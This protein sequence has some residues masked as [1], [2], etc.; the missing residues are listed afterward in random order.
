LA[1]VLVILLPFGYSL[2]HYAFAQRDETQQV[3]LERPDAQYEECV[4]ETTYMRFHH[5][6]LL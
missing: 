1:F 6:D 4:R 2:G 5:M 3:F